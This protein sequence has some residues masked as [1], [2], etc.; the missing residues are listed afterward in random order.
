VLQHINGLIE[1]MRLEPDERAAALRIQNFDPWK[2]EPLRPWYNDE[3]IRIAEE[4]MVE[5]PQ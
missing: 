2:V 4:Q 3:W 1:S 5:A